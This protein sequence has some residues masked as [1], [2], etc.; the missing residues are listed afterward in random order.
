MRCNKA[1]AI[2]QFSHLLLV[3]E[4]VRNVDPTQRD[5]E[6]R[7]ISD[8]WRIVFAVNKLRF[9]R[10]VLDLVLVV[11]SN[12]RVKFRGKFARCK[13]LRRIFPRPENF[14]LWETANIFEEE[15]ETEAR[16]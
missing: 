5:R 13:S 9:H 15:C 3:E 8:S 10:G 12:Q 14:F 11:H 4:H 16:R 7:N 1:F 2:S 6:A